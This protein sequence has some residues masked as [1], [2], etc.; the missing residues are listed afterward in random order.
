MN[1]KNR[2]QQSDIYNYPFRYLLI[3]DALPTDSYL[4]VI[5]SYNKIVFDAKS[6]Q[7]KSAGYDAD[8]FLLNNE[9]V[10]LFASLVSQEIV[11]ALAAKFDKKLESTI[12]AALHLHRP[13]NRSG[14]I[15][16]DFSPGWFDGNKTENLQL[17]N[18]GGLNY[19]NGKTIS[20]I[21]KPVMHIRA[22][23][24]IYFLNNQ[25][26]LN[27]GGQTGIYDSHLSAVDQPLIAVPPVSNSFLAF[28]CCPHSYHSFISNK[29]LRH[30][31]TYW[32]HSTPEAIKTRWPIE[33]LAYWNE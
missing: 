29:N 16:S 13:S 32:C 1:L 4:E 20:K 22:V 9:S 33:R 10:H 28:E 19:R 8:I 15:H 5:S 24:V 26:A 14:W 2:I 25:W 6:Q 18:T 3:N 31:I 11:E 17:S 27:D 21:V 7:S 30:S 12:D 23:T